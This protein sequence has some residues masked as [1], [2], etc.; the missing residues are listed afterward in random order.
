MFKLYNPRGRT[1]PLLPYLHIHHSVVLTFTVL[2]RLC[3]LER[4]IVDLIPWLTPYPLHGER[5]ASELFL[6]IKRIITELPNQAK[7]RIESTVC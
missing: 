1:L 7:L 5:S 4:M 3:M 2:L 6:S